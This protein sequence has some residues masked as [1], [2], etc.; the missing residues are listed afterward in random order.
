MAFWKIFCTE[1]VSL[2]AMLMR[3]K[4]LT[5]SGAGEHPSSGF[6]PQKKLKAIQVHVFKLLVHLLLIREMRDQ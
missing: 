3:Y 6:L 2:K 1:E 5:G 4:E